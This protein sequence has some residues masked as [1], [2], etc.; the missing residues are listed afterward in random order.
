[1]HKIVI[2]EGDESLRLYLQAKFLSLGFNV[3]PC[4]DGFEG[5]IKIKISSRLNYSEFRH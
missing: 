2:I 1:M 5:I 3:F 4:R